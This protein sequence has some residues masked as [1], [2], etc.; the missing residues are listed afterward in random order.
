MKITIEEMLVERDIISR[1]QLERVKE[2]QKSHEDKSLTDMLLLL[3]YTTEDVIMN[4]F[5]DRDDME[6][7]HL[8]ER[9]ADPAAIEM[10]PESFIVNNEIVPV[11]FEKGDLLVACAF[12]VDPDILEEAATISGMT[13][14]PVLTPADQIQKMLSG[15]ET[16]TEEKKKAAETGKTA[17]KVESAPAVRLVNTLIESAYKRNASDIHI[18]P[19]KEFLTIRFRIDGDLCMYTKM[20]MSY[21]RPVVTRLKLMGEMDIAEKR[22]PQDGKYRYEKEEMAT[23]LRI[24]TLPS[25]YGEKVVLRLL[26][27]DRDSSL[28]DVRRLGMDEKQEEIFGRMLKAPFGIILVTG[29]TGSGKSTTLYAA[30]SQLAEKKI[31][32]VTVED[33]VEKL[34]NGVTQVQVNAKAGLTFAT[35][36]RSIL[37]QDPDVI[38]VGEIRD[39]ETADIGVRAAVTGHLVLS[40]LHTNDCVSAVYRLQNMG[41][42]FYMIAAATTG[43]VAQRLVKVLCPHCRRKIKAGQQTKRLLYEV[44]G[45]EAE[46]VWEAVGCEECLN[47]GY[48]HRRAIYEMFELNETT[49]NMIRDGETAEKIR[50][51]QRERGFLSLQE[52]AAQMVM[53]GEM[54]MEEAEKVIYS[55][56]LKFQEN[57]KI[58]GRQCMKNRKWKEKRGFTLVELICVIAIM[59]IL[60]AVAVPSYSCIQEKSAKQVAI[61]N[62][63]AN[64]MQGKAQQEMVDAGVLA[65]SETEAYNYDASEDKATWEGEIGKKSYKAEYSGKT[66]EGYILSDDNGTDR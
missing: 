5:S 55:A 2:I 29:P 47:T 66:G 42:P 33:P 57:V 32:C 20:E 3:G 45:K 18:E 28:I 15:M 58:Q 30:L 24:S 1:Q 36:L 11:C 6:I 52:Q 40:T 4:C 7:I 8:E 38:M 14:R 37:R 53:C 49:K 39:E 13:I 48:S 9:T 31:N 22:L 56:E 51:Y 61:S 63:R 65:E 35:A 62:A 21:H 64:Y 12:P 34:I 16:I 43:V 17:E 19:G 27:N 59:G 10:L 41:I 60:M 50:R 25:V 23:D 26:G 46:E 44:S 54:D